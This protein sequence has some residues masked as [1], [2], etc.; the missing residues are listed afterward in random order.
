MR[1]PLAIA[2][3][4]PLCTAGDV[5]AN[6]R[7][8][9]RLIRAARARLVAFPELSL[10]GYELDAE[11]VAPDDERLGEIVAACAETGSIA[12]VGAPV[13][14]GAGRRHIGMLRV[15]SQGVGLAYRKSFLGG[16]EPA[17]FSPGNGP[18]AIDVDGWRVG[19]G[20]C[21]DT[22]VEQHVAD[23]G[24]LE[25]DLYVAGLV[26][27]PEELE[28]QDERGVRIARACR[29]YVAFAGCAG[30]TGGG[31]DRTAGA[32][33]IWAPDGKQLARAGAEPG[34]VIRALLPMDA[35]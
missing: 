18:V 34:H 22:G 3:A 28:L 26:H 1:R 31:F 10:T 15:T 23:S 24:A 17:R 14:G 35:A 7:E 5:P 19:L 8:H 29:A 13:P 2:A 20:I 30:P 12:L 21:R 27:R 16:D 6:A 32:S 9:A 4:Q 11:P 33:T 25:L